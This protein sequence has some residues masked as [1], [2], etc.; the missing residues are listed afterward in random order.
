MTVMADLAICFKCEECGHQQFTKYTLEL[1][2]EYQECIYVDYI[3]CEE[4]RH[5]NRVIEP[6]N[7][8]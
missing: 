5:T 1:R 4:C 3:D 2:F 6:V 8:R 7:Q